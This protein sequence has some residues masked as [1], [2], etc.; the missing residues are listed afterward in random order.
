MTYYTIADIEDNFKIVHMPPNMTCLQK[1]NTLLGDSTEWLYDVY[2]AFISRSDSY[3]S[4][5]DEF[6]ELCLDHN[7]DT[8]DRM[9][10]AV[11]L[12]RAKEL[13]WLDD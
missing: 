1:G 9:K 3:H 6:E 8:Y 4:L 2:E 12:G 13:G 5:N 7:I 10:I 11:L